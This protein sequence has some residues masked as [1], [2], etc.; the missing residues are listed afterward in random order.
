MAAYVPCNKGYTG[1][2]LRQ[3][4]HQ[5][6]PSTS[7]VSVAEA[8]SIYVCCR[9]LETA[10]QP[11]HGRSVVNL[12]I[13]LGRRTCR[14]TYLSERLVSFPIATPGDV[15]SWKRWTASASKPPFCGRR[16]I[17]RGKMESRNLRG[18][19]GSKGTRK[20]INNGAPIMTT[21]RVLH[22]YLL[23]RLWTPWIM[24]LIHHPKKD[25]K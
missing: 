20:S 5:D 10:L 12:T 17:P 9:A 21:K 2:S 7:H 13:Q 3:N 6:D 15:P 23:L 8:V 4:E 16:A 18:V 25:D 1:E 14:A 19:S 24:A 22:A 11:K